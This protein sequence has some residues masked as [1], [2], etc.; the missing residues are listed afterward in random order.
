[1]L[2]HYRVFTK[3]VRYGGGAWD[4]PSEAHLTHDGAVSV[5]WASSDQRPFE[6]QALYQWRTAD[7]LE[8]ET[9]VRAEKELAGFESFLANY[10]SE[11]F[12]NAAVYATPGSEEPAG[13][14]R[15]RTGAGPWQMFPRDPAVLA[16]IQDGRWRL[17]PNPV[18]W[19]VCPQFQRALAYRR[20]PVSELTVILMS[21]SADCFA[22][23]GP[24]ETEGHRSLYFSL[25]GRDLKAGQT[26]KART[27]LWIASS[28]S[29]ETILRAAEKPF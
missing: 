16:I 26:L 2:S 13:F 18:A 29:P 23:A 7:T 11:S 14:V 21:P 22:I 4:W 5:I 27:R 15:L 20:E 28:P 19:T 12:T 17:E 10:F 1:L 6:M 9:S 8:L 25:F 3:G 24:E